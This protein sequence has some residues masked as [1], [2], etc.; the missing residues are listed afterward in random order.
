MLP[1][2][3]QDLRT[4]LCP[5]CGASN[6]VS[7]ANCHHCGCDLRLPPRHRREASNDSVPG[8]PFASDF[9][10]AGL[11]PA[12]SP[13]LGTA[14]SRRVSSG[15]EFGLVGDAAPIE[16]SIGSLPRRVWGLVGTVFLVGLAVAFYLGYQQRSVSEVQSRQASTERAANGAEARAAEGVR[17]APVAPPAAAQAP[18]TLA[19]PPAQAPTPRPQA[20]KPDRPTALAAPR[21]QHKAARSAESRA[22]ATARAGTTPPANDGQAPRFGPCTPAVAALGLC[23]PDAAKGGN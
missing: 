3:I 13:D 23:T 11:A 22:T 9:H 14:G 7:V 16:A 1:T 20:A 12:A 5:R 19:P 4:A 2:L 10:P 17:A 21:Q 8:D 18:V 15:S 6:D